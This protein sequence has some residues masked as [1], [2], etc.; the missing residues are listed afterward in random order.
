MDYWAT[1]IAVNWGARNPALV[2]IVAKFSGLYT[3]KTLPF[4]ALLFAFWFAI[5]NK[6]ETRR[7]VIGGFIGAFV[8]LVVARIVQNFAPHRPRPAYSGEFDI[9]PLDGLPADWSSF[10]SD[11]ISIV[12][13]IS[14]AIFLISRPLGV[15]A[16]A[17]AILWVAMAKL[18]TGAHYVSDLVAGAVIGIGSTW[19]VARCTAMLDRVQTA[20]DRIRIR[21]PV[22]FYL[23]A[24]T[25][26][27]QI[28]TFF[29][30]PRKI[31]KGALKSAGIVKEASQPPM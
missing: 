7:N 13:A 4:V 19:L 3:F 11:T 16:F 29:D 1:G 2:S 5:N 30:E 26:V 14:T 28:G 9:A 24:F 22:A 21:A 17:F 6:R 15:G 12:A 31:A 10:P 27:F 8:A 25:F 23:I 20:G 18:V